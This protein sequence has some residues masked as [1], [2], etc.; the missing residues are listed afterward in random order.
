MS[1]RRIPTIYTLIFDGDLE[2]LTVR[3]KSI[4]F[5]K[6]RQLLA[7]MDQEDKDTETMD[8]IAKMLADSIVSWDFQD[9]DGND[10][11]VTAEAVDDLEFAEVMAIT[12]KWLDQ[13]TGPDAELGKGSSSGGTFPGRPLTM[14]AL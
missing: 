8:E 1:R 13:I 11:P 5:G 3:I 2:G 6:V 9:E 10:I 14:D 4:K 7:L 12:N